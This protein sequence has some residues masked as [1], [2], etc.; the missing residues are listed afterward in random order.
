MTTYYNGLI[1]DKISDYADVE[2]LLGLDADTL[3]EVIWSV[4]VSTYG[5]NT[6]QTFNDPAE[7]EEIDDIQVDSVEIGTETGYL[8]A[9]KEQIELL[10]KY[11]PTDDELYW[12]IITNARVDK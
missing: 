9:T 11:R 8:V 12:N 1:Y 5:K 3:T 10:E 7:F 4:S 2:S 6:P